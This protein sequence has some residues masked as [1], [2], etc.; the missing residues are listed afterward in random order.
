MRKEAM[1]FGLRPFN[2]LASCVVG[3]PSWW[4]LFSE[5]STIP[6]RDPETA[7]F[8]ILLAPLIGLH[9]PLFFYLIRR[10]RFQ[11]ACWNIACAP[12]V[13]V[14]N[15]FLCLVVTLF[16]RESSI[17]VVMVT[18]LWL[19]PFVSIIFIDERNVTP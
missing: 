4:M 2:I 10:S 3:V 13:S 8:I 14:F 17:A 12:F 19:F 9:L 18:L 11:A 16:V 7:V 15:F 5:F 6:H 1:A